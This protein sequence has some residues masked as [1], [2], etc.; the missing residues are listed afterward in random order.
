MFPSDRK[1]FTFV[2]LN[3]SLFA[4]YFCNLSS[5]PCILNLSSKSLLNFLSSA[6]ST[7]YIFTRYFHTVWKYQVE[8]NSRLL[9]DPSRPISSC[10][11][12]AILTCL[13][14]LSSLFGDSRGMFT[15]RK[16]LSPKWPPCVRLPQC[17]LCLSP[18]EPPECFHIP[19]SAS[20]PFWGGL[21]AAGASF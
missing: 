8:M 1:H 13:W 3:L 4:L 21:S 11:F 20:H 16:A 5:S 18:T 9:K 2:F 19:P 15:S 6:D 14:K 17:P 10:S 12:I 7:V